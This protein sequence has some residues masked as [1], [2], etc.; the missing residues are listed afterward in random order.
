MLTD[1]L[2]SVYTSQD[3]FQTRA[4]AVG[5]KVKN[6]I[7]A[8][9]SVRVERAPNEQ[10]DSAKKLSREAIHAVEHAMVQFSDSVLVAATSPDSI[11]L[12]ITRDPHVGRDEALRPIAVAIHDE[13]NHFE[14]AQK[15]NIGVA[16]DITS[17]SEVARGLLDACEIADAGRDN[18]T[19]SLYLEMPDVH[20]RGLLFL[21]R[22]DHRVQGFIEREIGPLLALNST[23]RRDLM[24]TLSTFLQVGR[25]K[26]LAADALHMS[27][28]AVYHRLRTIEDLLGVDLY[29]V[30]ACLS[31]HVAIIAHEER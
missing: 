3:E 28:P 11:A 8:P 18:T 9:V 16:G 27:R 26:S 17:L 5:V 15:V 31:L 7:F 25:N 22:A 21:L 20:V 6:R 13:F 19:F 1:I 24:E 30:E 14:P 12:L 23:H 2:G 10:G 4:A 29:D